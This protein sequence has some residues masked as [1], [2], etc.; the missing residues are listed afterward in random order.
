MSTPKRGFTLIELLIVMVILGL[1]GV[2]GVGNFQSARMK[3]RDVQRKSDL[4][5][6]AKSLEAYN[7]DHRAYP[8]SDGSGNIS[9]SAPATCAWGQP[10]SDGTSLYAAILPE[11]GHDQRDYYYQSNGTSYTLYAA[12]EN[13]NDPAVQVIPGAIPCGTVDCNYKITSSNLTP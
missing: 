12:L 5:T 3:A 9:C 11:D 6:I 13:E 2:L 10:F 8:T 4:A 7:N 1:L